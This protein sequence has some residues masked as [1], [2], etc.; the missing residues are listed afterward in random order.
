MHRSLRRSSHKVFRAELSDRTAWVFFLAI[1][2]R[3]LELWMARLGCFFHV[4]IGPA[5]K[6][7]RILSVLG[8]LIVADGCWPRRGSVSQ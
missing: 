3:N 4:A 5:N 8:G 2:L 7:S 1:V 6:V